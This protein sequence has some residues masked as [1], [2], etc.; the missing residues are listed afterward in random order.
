MFLPLLL[1]LF[2]FHFFQAEKGDIQL[3]MNNLRSR[4][5]K[6]LISIFQSSDGFPSDEKKSFKS[7][8]LQPEA[9][10]K[11]EDI[12]PGKY[13]LAILH[14]EDKNFKMTYHWT[15]IPKEGFGFSM[16]KTG[17]LK[18]PSFE[19]AA[20]QHSARGTSLDIEMHY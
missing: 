11:L 8:V 14:D 12:P 3:K 6:I 1:L 9:V 17:L 10:L 16:V 2:S 18:I 19:K 4:N 20:F 15:G 5:G 7:W 13:A